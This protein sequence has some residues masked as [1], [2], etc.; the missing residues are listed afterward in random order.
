MFANMGWPSDCIYNI[1]PESGSACEGGADIEHHFKVDGKQNVWTQRRKDKTQ[2]VEQ[3]LVDYA[4]FART[5]CS[6]SD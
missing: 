3:S 4:E 6:G 2:Q 5:R 1:T